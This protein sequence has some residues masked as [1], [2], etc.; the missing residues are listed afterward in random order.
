M[1]EEQKSEEI[2]GEIV[3]LY[4]KLVLEVEAISK[5]QKGLILAR[6]LTVAQVVSN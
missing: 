3:E 5:R 6:N 2:F 1:S 4:Y